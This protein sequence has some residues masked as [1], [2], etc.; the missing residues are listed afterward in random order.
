MNVLMPTRKQITSRDFIEH[1]H[2]SAS[3]DTHFASATQ[4]QALPFRMSKRHW[5]SAWV[6]GGDGRQQEP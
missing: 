6:R 4:Q 5:C 3:D 1:P 2:V